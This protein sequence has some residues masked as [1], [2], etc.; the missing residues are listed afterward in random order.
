MNSENNFP[1]LPQN[2]EAEMALL[3]A[4]FANNHAYEAVSELLRAEHFA[5]GQNKRV[6]EACGK[7]ID[8]GQIADQ[9]TLRTFFEADEGLSKMGGTAYLKELTGSAVGIINAGEYARIIYDLYLRR[10]LIHLSE[11]IAK[12]AYSGD[13]EDSGVRQIERA[14]QDLYDLATTGQY[15]GGFC[16][17]EGAVKDAVSSTIAASRWGEDFPG[18]VTRINELDEKMGGLFRSDL[19][20][21]AGRPSM[22]MRALITKIALNAA[23]SHIQSNGEKGGVVGIFSLD[24]SAQMYGRQAIA[25]LMQLPSDGQ[26]PKSISSL[27]GENLVAASRSFF[28]LPI[29]IDD[30]PALTCSA[31]R[32]RARRLK[33]QH[34]LDLIVVD[35]LQ[36]IAAPAKQLN[37]ERLQD[38]S[39]ITRELKTL[40]RELAVPVLL[41][42]QLSDAVDK[43]DDKRPQIAD[44]RK[45][46]PIERDA[47]LILFMFKESYYLEQE[48][49][50]REQDESDIPY[51]NRI[52]RWE[53]LCKSVLGKVDVIIARNRYGLKGTVTLHSEQ[54]MHQ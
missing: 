21:L 10:E 7:L 5:L 15:E 19:V 47:D 53:E 1:N 51:R 35:Y 50:V 45:F 48:R 40:A 14:E 11:N 33:R 38:Y 49:P 26:K 42:C 20:M 32:T 2:I 29:F 54:A 30:T 22:G 23:T 8:R 43:R 39:A 18:V 17:F 9:V 28:G 37:D 4:I 44:L 34:G 36:L 27:E 6:Y 12:R 25:E 41:L 46:G 31:L 16:D 13:V 3:G 52:E 24:V